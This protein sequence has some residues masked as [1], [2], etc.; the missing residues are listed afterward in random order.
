MSN[1]IINVFTVAIAPPP[2]FYT[3]L[4]F[5]RGFTWSWKLLGGGGGA[6]ATVKSY[7]TLI[8]HMRKKTLSNNDLLEL[9]EENLL[10]AFIN[11]A[12]RR[13]DLVYIFQCTIYV[14]TL[15]FCSVS[16]EIL[17][18]FHFICF[19]VSIFKTRLRNR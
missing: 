15:N 3:D 8:L 14:F 5:S 12:T 7:F 10:K 11:M 16:Y 6:I 4:D 17:K 19:R 13:M 18:Y 1:H 2:N 9:D